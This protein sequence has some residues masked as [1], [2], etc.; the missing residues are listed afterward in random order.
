MARN[1]KKNLITNVTCL[2]AFPL[3]A[4]APFSLSPLYD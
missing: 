3:D 1:C 4:P 2:R